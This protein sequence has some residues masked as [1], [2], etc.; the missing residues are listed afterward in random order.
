MKLLKRPLSSSGT[1]LIVRRADSKV[2]ILTARH[3]VTDSKT[4]ATSRTCDSVQV[5]I[6]LGGN[7]P[8][9][10][11]VTPIVSSKIKVVAD[12][13]DLDLA[14]IEIDAPNLPADIQPLPFSSNAKEQSPVTV[15][16]HPDDQE[17]QVIQGKITDVS[18]SDGLQ[19][20][21][22]LSRGNS[23]GPILNQNYEILGIAVS[24]LPRNVVF[25]VPTNRIL[26][27]LKEWGITVP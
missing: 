9:T 16:G 13:V 19:L 23:G 8:I 1:G 26:K 17:W 5:L 4:F 11:S 18:A 12:K 15:I 2:W 3:V 25:A 24:I 20:K 21:A 7:K 22:G 6:Y 27:Q 10:A 14:L